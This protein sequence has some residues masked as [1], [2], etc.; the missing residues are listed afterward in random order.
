M[1]MYSPMGKK[2][3]FVTAFI[4]LLCNGFPSVAR[5]KEKVFVLYL[6]QK[7]CL[8]GWNLLLIDGTK[9]EGYTLMTAA[10]SASISAYSTGKQVHAQ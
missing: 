1:Y 8:K 3:L 2:A 6:K 10:V 5:R 4:V 9:A 7:Q